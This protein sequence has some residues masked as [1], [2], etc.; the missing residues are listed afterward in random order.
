MSI[1]NLEDNEWSQIIAIIANSHPLIAK[2]STQLVAQRG[3]GYAGAK[4][5]Q[6]SQHSEEKTPVAAYPRE[7][8]A[9]GLSD[10]AGD[11]HGKR[12][13]EAGSEGEA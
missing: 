5:H 12:S 7:R 8:R 9:P 10:G 13:A 2:I 11:S 3:N 1:V 6:E 4:A